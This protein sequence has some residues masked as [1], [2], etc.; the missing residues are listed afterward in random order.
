MEDRRL[1]VN[2]TAIVK[3]YIL[4]CGLVQGLLIRKIGRYT[5][6]DGFVLT[7]LEHF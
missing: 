4:M 7:N 5:L 2:P 6:D 1:L 3:F